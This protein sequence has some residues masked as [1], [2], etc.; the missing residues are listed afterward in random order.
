MTKSEKYAR[1]EYMSLFD[2]FN[3]RRPD[4]R[5]LITYTVDVR[6][7][8]Q[9]YQTILQLLEEL[10]ASCPTITIS[11][12]PDGITFT[13]SIISIQNNNHFVIKYMDQDLHVPQVHF[14]HEQDIGDLVR[15]ILHYNS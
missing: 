13:V 10:S 1:Y 8:E 15:F 12:V 11:T 7:E 3:R 9:G 4:S 5:S 14:Y 2:Y 6:N